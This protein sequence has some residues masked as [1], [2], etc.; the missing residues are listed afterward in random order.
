MSGRKQYLK[1][2]QRKRRE[3]ETI[4]ETAKRRKDDRMR[5]S[6]KRKQETIAA[7]QKRLNSNRTRI[8]QK[9][10]RAREEKRAEKKRKRRKQEQKKENQEQLAAL[11]QKD[12]C[13]ICRVEMVNCYYSPCGHMYCCLS[14]AKKWFFNCSSKCPL[15]N[16]EVKV[17][18]ALVDKTRMMIPS[19]QQRCEDDIEL[20]TLEAEDARMDCCVVC[21][22]EASQEDMINC[23][24]CE[25]SLHEEC[26]SQHTCE[27]EGEEPSSDSEYMLCDDE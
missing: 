8:A 23:G 20:M 15:C 11:K 3:K 5:K 2:W 24:F 14:C 10:K 26:Q 1:D 7:K 25:G 13:G 12:V 22:Q 17:L 19:K 6:Q 27:S 18:T 21:G 9:R 4:E 16:Q